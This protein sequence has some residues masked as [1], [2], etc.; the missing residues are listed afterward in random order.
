MKELE[1][2]YQQCKDKVRYGN[3]W[4]S[5]TVAELIEYSRIKAKRGGIIFSADSGHV[6]KSD[7]MTEKKRIES[8]IDDLLDAANLCI[9]AAKRIEELNG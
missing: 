5:F 4:S 7:Y 2:L 1:H 3:L 8:S 9:M 6:M